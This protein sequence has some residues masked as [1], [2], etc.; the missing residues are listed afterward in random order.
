MARKKISDFPEL[1]T[2]HLS[3]FTQVVDEWTNYQVSL[4]TLK[5][6]LVDEQEHNFLGN[7]SID[8]DLSIIGD[9]IINGKLLEKSTNVTYSELVTLISTS[10]LT[11]GQLYRLTDF[12]T[13]H[14][15]FNA[16]VRLNDIN[17]GANEVLYL[18]A[19]SSSS[20]MDTCYSE[21]Y[22]H[23][24]M[25][26]DWNPDNWLKDI[27]F[28]N[29]ENMSGSGLTIDLSAVSIINGFKGVIYFRHDLYNNNQLGYD[30]RNVKFR[31][32]KLN[33]PVWSSG[34]TYNLSQK[35]QVLNNGAYM[36]LIS[37]N[38]NNNTSNAT[39]WS[40][41]IDYSYSE[42]YCN[43][44]TLSSNPLDF[45]DVLTFSEQSGTTIYDWCVRNNTFEH[46]KYGYD[47]LM[48]SLGSILSNNVFYLGNELT[49]FIID[50]KLDVFFELNTV[51]PG[52]QRNDINHYCLNNIIGANCNNNTI[53]HDFSLNIIDGDFNENTIGNNFRFNTISNS[54]YGNVIQDYFQFNKIGFEFYENI[55]SNWFST[56]TVHSVCFRN[57]F[58][59]VFVQNKVQNGFMNNEV[60]SSYLNIIGN[61][62]NF[63]IIGDNFYNNEISDTFTK[64]IINNG[65]YQNT[66]GIDFTDNSLG[67]N[68][69]FNTILIGFTGNTISS[70]FLTNTIGTGFTDNEISTNFNLNTIGGGFHANTIESSFNNNNIGNG[71]K[72]NSIQGDFA[73]NVIT[74]NFTGN[75]I[76][77]R[78]NNN[79]IGD[80][81]NGNSTGINTVNLTIPDHGLVSGTT[82]NL[83]RIRDGFDGT[84]IDFSSAT[85]V[86]NQYNCELLKTSTGTYK[87]SYVDGTDDTIKV[88][89]VNT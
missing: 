1:L 6:V 79:D 89:N 43:D 58:L 84:G 22:P 17:I 34:S 82:F 70:N 42:Y 61:N 87:L 86:Y 3:G 33:Y 16:A 54:F 53:N 65:F 32:W 67:D 60:G 55:I 77:I 50:N 15:M 38:T 81:F 83:N 88:V 68:F 66:I 76:G 11:S 4:E 52:F 59:E 26:Y 47:Y 85:H 14:Y 73:S 18:T 35:V 64:N 63:N 75:Q 44:S 30:F 48:G 72:Y 46:I 45:I 8:G 28:A 31:R 25:Q 56:N 37:G 2:P 40:K 7:Q 19:N 5:N 27:G 24:I 23:D 20:I 36:S 13:V 57:K 74:N 39:Y 12:Q 78:F 29:A 10:G 80:N 71:F 49:N 69:K 9:L 41:I 62:F 21:T 51:S